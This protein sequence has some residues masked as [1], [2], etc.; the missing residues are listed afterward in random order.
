MNK[1]S[2]KE[3]AVLFKI[4]NGRAFH[5]F[6][7]TNE[8]A[9]TK[10]YLKDGAS[11]YKGIFYTVNGYAGKANLNKDYCYLSKLKAI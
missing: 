7:A 4:C 3:K 1:G 11:K 8:R 5:G 6:D 9:I 2:L 10:C